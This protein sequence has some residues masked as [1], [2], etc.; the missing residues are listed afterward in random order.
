MKMRG[1][2][3][4]FRPAERAGQH[5]RVARR[6]VRDWNADLRRL[7]DCD[8]RIRERGAADAAEI[9]AQRPMLDRAERARDPCRGIELG[10]VALSVVEAQRMAAVAALARDRERRGGIEAAREQDDCA[11]HHLPRHVAP[12]HLVQLDLQ[13]H[14]Q[15]LIEDPLRE[16]ARLRPG[17]SSG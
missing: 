8:R 11:L 9:D 4:H 2:L 12:E 10:A 16:V 3:E 1:A 14:R 6:D 7:G 15:A 17:R 13:P 5:H